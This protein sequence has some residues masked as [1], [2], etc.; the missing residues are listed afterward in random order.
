MRDL[1]SKGW[2]VAKGIAFLG[3]AMATA[4]LL[5]LDAPSL[6]T[7]ALLCLL[8]WAAWRFYYFLFYVLEHYVDPKLRY[9]GIADLIRAAILKRRRMRSSQ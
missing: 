6:R 5:L 8:V 4:V 9:S 1:Q 2:I 7:A 3:I